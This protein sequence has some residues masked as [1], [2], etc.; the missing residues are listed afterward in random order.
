MSPVIVASIVIQI[1]LSYA[2]EKLPAACPKSTSAWFSRITVGIALVFTAAQISVIGVLFGWGIWGVTIALFVLAIVPPISGYIENKFR[3]NGPEVFAMDR[4]LSHLVTNL[5]GS[6]AVSA[7][8]W[9]AISTPQFDT[10]VASFGDDAAFNIV[11]PLASA[12]ALAFARSEQIKHSGGVDLDTAPADVAEQAI[13]G[14]SLR[15]VHQ[16][17]NTIHLTVMVFV[18]GA[19]MLYLFAQTMSSAK[20]GSPL[21][22]SWQVVASVVLT[23][24]FFL[25]CGLPIIRKDSRAI[26]MT[27]ATG[28]PAAM[29]IALVWLALFAEDT[30]RNAAIVLVLGGAYAAYSVE[31]ILAER[32]SKRKVEA[33]YFASVVV[34]FS[35]LMLLGAIYVS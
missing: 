22:V 34:T 15:H 11:L 12:V 23:L 1:A 29:G 31:M 6:L 27:F 5:L 4:F 30:L 8:V 18:A 14:Y 7:F 32:E 17:T 24:V 2:Q 26:W 25:A 19:T 13:T 16:L 35:L 20:E 28:T 33:H 21:E 10:F 3:K 9:A